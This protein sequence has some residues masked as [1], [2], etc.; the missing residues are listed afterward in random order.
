MT[1]FIGDIARLPLLGEILALASA[2]AWAIAV[3]LFRVSGKSVPPVGLNLFKNAFAFLLILAVMLALGRDPFPAAAFPDYALLLASGI[4]GIAVSDTLFLMALNA[5]GAGLL[6]IVDCAYSPFVIILSYIFLGE[7]LNP[8]QLSGVLLIA[9]AIGLL[10]W[11]SPAENGGILRKDLARGVILGILAMLTVAIGIVMI[12]P[13]LAHTDVLW[14]TFMRIVGGIAGLILVLP[15]LP[16]RKEILRPLAV[17]ANWKVMIPA[18]FFGSVLSLFF[19]VAGMK[20]ALATVAAILNQMN[21]FFIF[22]LAAVFLKEKATPW[23][24]A[25]VVVAFLG[26]F[27]ASFPG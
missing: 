11:K 24:I 10:A 7:R 12:K 19:W 8:W 18:S 22:I 23:K 21:V 4:L 3:I 15:F 13:M 2:A 9:G 25:A 1:G 27:L 20:Y 16:R 14:A 17:P 5:L 6:A 26:A